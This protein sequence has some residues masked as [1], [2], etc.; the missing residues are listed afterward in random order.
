[1]IKGGGPPE[2]GGRLSS[3]FDIKM[4]EGN[5]KNFSSSGGIGLVSSRLAL[6]GPINEGQGSYFISGRRTYADLVMKTAAPDIFD[7]FELY[8]YDLNMKAN[9]NI[10]KYD[11]LYL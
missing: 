1:L 5:R 2:Y 8:F 7:D 10:G 3:V 6:E 9:Y 11:Y 4:K